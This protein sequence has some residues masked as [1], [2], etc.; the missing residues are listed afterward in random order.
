MNIRAT[1]TPP[2]TIQ[3]INP[4]LIIKAME[5]TRLIDG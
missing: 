2:N 3:I 5:I 1:T 4:A